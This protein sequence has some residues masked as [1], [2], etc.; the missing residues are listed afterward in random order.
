[1]FGM[2]TI[3]S[4]VYNG[5]KIEVREDLK[6]VYL[7]VNDVECDF[8]SGKDELNHTTKDGTKIHVV[9]KQGLFNIS[10]NMYVNDCQITYRKNYKKD[11]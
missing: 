11:N 9:F 10:M 5:L 1:M 3:Y 8:S 7:Y 6:R 4:H 2:K